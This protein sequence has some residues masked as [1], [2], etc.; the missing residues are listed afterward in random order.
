MCTTDI[1]FLLGIGV[2]VLFCAGTLVL[3]TNKSILQDTGKIE[4]A[5][6][7]RRNI[8]LKS[9][10]IWLSLYYWVVLN[11]ILTTLFVIYISCYED[12][13]KDE[14]RVRIFFYSS[15]SLFLA[16]CPYIV[17]MMDVSKAYRKAYCLLDDAINSQG[18]IIN[19]M[20]EG[21]CLIA[22]AHK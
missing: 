16:I 5:I 19:A 13:T 18:N 17:N 10:I 11:S 14:M 6:L 20:K 7:K 15:V 9:S 3:C 12:M 4:K 1:I 8:W 2:L 22:E 21:E